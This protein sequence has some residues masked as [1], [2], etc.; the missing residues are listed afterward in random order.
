[1]KFGMYI[2]QNRAY[3]GNEDPAYIRVGVW[4]MEIEQGERN[5]K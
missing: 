4:G 5:A 1:M 3:Q 2:Y